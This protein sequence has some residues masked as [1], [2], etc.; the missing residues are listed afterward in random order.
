MKGN[1]GECQGN[2][3]NAGEYRGMP[4]GRMGVGAKCQRNAGECWVMQAYA[5]RMYRSGCKVR[6]EYRGMPGEPIGVVGTKGR[7]MLGNARRTYGSGCKLPGECQGNVWEVY[8]A[9]GMQG[10]MRG[11]QGSGCKVLAE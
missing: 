10:T 2:A 11:M 9:R 6:E 8:S 4:E 3:G 1:A 5:K 7:G